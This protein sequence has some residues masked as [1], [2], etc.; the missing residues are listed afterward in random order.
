MQEQQPLAVEEG[1][2]SVVLRVLPSSGG[3]TPGSLETPP[4]KLPCASA[5]A[6]AGPAGWMQGGGAVAN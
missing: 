5:R 2:R 3:F 6:L 1:E 4:G